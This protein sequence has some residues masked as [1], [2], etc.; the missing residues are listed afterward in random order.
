MAETQTITPS[1]RKANGAPPPITD[2]QPA[3]LPDPM[4]V[5]AGIP[6]PPDLE[7]MVAEIATL[8][9]K[10]DGLRAEMRELHREIRSDPTAEPRVDRQVGKLNHEIIEI[11]QQI[12]FLRGESRLARSAHVQQTTAALKRHRVSAA[13]TVRA[14]FAALRQARDNLQACIDAAGETVIGKMLI[15]VI[16]TSDVERC[17]E[18]I[19]R[20][21]GLEP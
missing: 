18:A 19:L 9:A 20:Q 3:P 16:P 11:T 15:P 17:A 7:A 12:A 10:R 1:K 6:M 21:E 4:T 13:L 5:V 8:T 14:S 2:E